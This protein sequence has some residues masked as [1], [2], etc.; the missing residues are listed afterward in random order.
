MGRGRLLGQPLHWQADRIC[1]HGEKNIT[2]H[3]SIW[4]SCPI[5]HCEDHVALIEIIR[6]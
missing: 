4:H 2:R 6:R 1:P 3:T 5:S